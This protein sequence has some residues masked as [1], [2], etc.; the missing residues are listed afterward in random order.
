MQQLQ[1]ENLQVQG[2]RGRVIWRIMRVYTSLFMA[3]CLLSWRLQLGSSGEEQTHQKHDGSTVTKMLARLGLGP[4]AD[5]AAA[6]EGDQLPACTLVEEPWQLLPK[7]KCW[8]YEKG[9]SK[10]NRLFVPQ[11]EGPPAPW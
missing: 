10:E 1:K 4:Q 8:G 11:C 5:M 6:C 9:C 7:E 3:W 2:P